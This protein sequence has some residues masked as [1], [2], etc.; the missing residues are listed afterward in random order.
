MH[1][2]FCLSKIL[3]FLVQSLN[4]YKCFCS[5][6]HHIIFGKAIIFNLFLHPPPLTK[7]PPPTSA[8]PTLEVQIGLGSVSPLDIRSKMEIGCVSSYCSGLCPAHNPFLAEHW[9]D[10]PCEAQPAYQLL[11]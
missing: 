4:F 1:I 11:C 5:S 3:T 9:L 6:P 10:R 2:F 8:S 7:W